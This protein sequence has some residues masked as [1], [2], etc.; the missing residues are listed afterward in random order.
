MPCLAKQVL[1]DM[2]AVLE[3]YNSVCYSAL[4]TAQHYMR[5]CVLWQKSNFFWKKM[6]VALQKCLNNLLKTFGFKCPKSFNLALVTIICPVLFHRYGLGCVIKLKRRPSVHTMMIT[7]SCYIT[8]WY[9]CHFFYEN[10]HEL[11]LDLAKSK[12]WISC[13]LLCTLYLYEMHHPLAVAIKFAVR[14]CD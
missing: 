12:W 11:Q 5:G 4:K 8:H 7:S 3:I 10:Y 13:T 6:D 2:C 14:L 1:F 9:I